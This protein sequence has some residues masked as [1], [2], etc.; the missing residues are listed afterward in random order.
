MLRASA[1]SAYSEP[2]VDTGSTVP[3]KLDALALVSG[4]VA[5]V[6]LVGSLSG[7]VKEIVKHFEEFLLADASTWTALSDELPTWSP[8]TMTS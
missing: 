5:G 1:P 4:T 6:D 7:H 8:T 3:M 2:E